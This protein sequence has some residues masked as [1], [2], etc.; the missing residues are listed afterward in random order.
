MKQFKV[1]FFKESMIKI[2]K[3]MT[4]LFEEMSNESWKS[5]V[6][7]NDEFGPFKD[8]ENVF[9]AIKEYLSKIK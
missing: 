8:Y 3:K 2:V 5:T 9:G 4:E 6:E 7:F 1:H